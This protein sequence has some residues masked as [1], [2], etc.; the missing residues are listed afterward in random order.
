MRIAHH[1]P[2]RQRG[3]SL[4]ELMVGIAVGMFVVA[5]ATML[6][7]TQLIDNR[8]LLLETQI[9]QDLRATADIITRELRRVGHWER[10]RDAVWS[11]GGAGIRDNPYGAWAI[12]A[13]GDEV[14]MSLSRAALEVDENNAVDES[15]RLGFRLNNGV[16]ETKLGNAGWQALTDGSTMRVTAFNVALEAAAPPAPASGAPIIACP[17]DCPGG[18]TA[19]WPT[20][21]TQQ[22]VVDITAEAAN[23]VRVQRSVRTRVRVRNDAVVN[24]HLPDVALCPV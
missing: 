1:S 24:N 23:D 19:C 20:L 8:Q 7:A 11:A 2:G 6:A 21:T 10:A 13:D 22:F 12:N 17:N 15:D 18:G 16:I 14:T 3:L 9:Q 4:V 5:G